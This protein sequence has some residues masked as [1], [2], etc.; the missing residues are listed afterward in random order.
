MQMFI[1]TLLSIKRSWDFTSR[2]SESLKL[3]INLCNKATS[4]IYL[5]VLNDLKIL[6]LL[7]FGPPV[8]KKHITIRIKSI[9]L[10][11]I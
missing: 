2:E 5:V 3:H 7:N 6:R 9:K 11:F 4:L 10:T 8:R 1:N